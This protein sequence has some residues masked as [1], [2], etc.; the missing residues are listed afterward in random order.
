MRLWEL[1][2]F[3]HAGEYLHRVVAPL[4]VG[5]RVDRPILARLVRGLNR[6]F[7]GMLTER[8][9]DLYLATSPSFSYARV[10]RLLEETVSVAPRRGERVDIEESNG[11][12]VLGVYLARDIRCGFTLTLT[13]YEFLSR[14]AEGALPGSFS[15]ECYEDLLAF[16]SHVLARL[17]ERRH[18]DG[19]DQARG[20]VFKLLHLDEA[21]SISTKIIEAVDDAA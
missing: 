9:S 3:Q 13:R 12:P 1:T 6:I 8:D 14:V 7:T 20:L 21:G 4:R 16:K 17:D 19:E 11:F 2:V 15:R 5:G 18:S 10:S